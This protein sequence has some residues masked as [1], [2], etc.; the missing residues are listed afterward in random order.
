MKKRIKKI[1]SKTRKFKYFIKIKIFNNIKKHLK[2]RTTN[3][4]L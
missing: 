2:L 3:Y 1:I 4:N